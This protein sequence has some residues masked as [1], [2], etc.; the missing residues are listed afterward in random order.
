MCRN[1]ADEKQAENKHFFTQEVYK[2]EALKL[3]S[4]TEV[5]KLESDN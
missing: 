5:G 3:E 1:Y 2:A 4:P